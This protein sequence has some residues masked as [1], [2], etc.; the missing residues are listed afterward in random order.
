[1]KPNKPNKPKTTHNDHC[2]HCNQHIPD[3]YTEWAYNDHQP[4]FDTQCPH[5]NQH[6]GAYV[7]QTPLYTLSTQT[8]QQRDQ[9]LTQHH[10]KTK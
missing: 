2:P 10:N 8:N 4:E 6:I 5:C 9:Q 7:E 3:L 1:M